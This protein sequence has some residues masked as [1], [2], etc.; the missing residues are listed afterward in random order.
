MI[1]FWYFLGAG[2]V[3]A[4]KLGRFLYLAP[5]HGK[6]RKQSFCDWFFAPTAENAV[7]WLTTCGVVWILGSWYVGSFHWGEDPQQAIPVHSAMAFTLG[8]LA[9]LIAPAVAKKLTAL[10]V[11]QFGSES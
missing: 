11:S 8:T 3:L 9:E 5:Q 10:V 1:L 6:T 4:Y 7:S 2:G